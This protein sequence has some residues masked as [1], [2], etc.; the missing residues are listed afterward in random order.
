VWVALVEQGAVCPLL[1][2]KIA[3]QGVWR[4]AGWGS[5]VLVASLILRGLPG[6][7]FVIVRD[8]ALA[9]FGNTLED[10]WCVGGGSRALVNLRKY[11]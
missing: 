3:P 8:C 5:C 7:V 1:A 9:L 6:R 11:P 10:A 2:G 4:L